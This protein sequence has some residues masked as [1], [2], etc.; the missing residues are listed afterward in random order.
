MQD[1]NQQLCGR[2]VEAVTEAERLRSLVSGME[3]LSPRLRA[4]E[5]DRAQ[6]QVSLTI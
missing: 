2:L 4:S 5:A 3:G 1:T 6:M